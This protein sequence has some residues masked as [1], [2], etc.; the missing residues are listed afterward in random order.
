VMFLY[1]FWVIVGTIICEGLNCVADDLLVM[2]GTWVQG[3]GRWCAA[4]IDAL[5]CV[6]DD[7]LAMVTSWVQGF[8]H[9]Y[10][11]VTDV[12]VW[13]GRFWFHVYVWRERLKRRERLYHRWRHRHKYLLANQYCFLSSRVVHHVDLV[14]IR[15]LS[16]GLYAIY[17][18]MVILHATGY[19]YHVGFTYYLISWLVGAMVCCALLSLC[20]LYDSK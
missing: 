17:K 7:F 10:A 3:F 14:I 5:R 18:Y 19:L 15:C 12:V 6:A 11:T 20:V 13:Y 16:I 1:W 4:A 8:G 2:V 9:W